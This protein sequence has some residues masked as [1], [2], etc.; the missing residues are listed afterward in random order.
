[1]LCPQC[2]SENPQHA[3]RCSRCGYNLP[4]SEIKNPNS[5]QP[6]YT[7]NGQP[8][9]SFVGKAFISLALYLLACWIF[10]LISNIIFL[11][12]ANKIKKR[13]ALPLKD[14]AV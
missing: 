14:M 4:P 3:V 1:M 2:N 13:Q 10:G 8:Q 5:P 6:A 7:S 12:D 11:V 9:K